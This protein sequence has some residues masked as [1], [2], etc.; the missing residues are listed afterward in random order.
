MWV[1]NV[2]A[3]LELGGDGIIASIDRWPPTTRSRLEPSTTATAASHGQLRGRR[4]AQV[5]HV[6]ERPRV[7]LLKPQAE[8]RRGAVLDVEGA[9]GEAITQLDRNARGD[10]GDAEVEPREHL[11]QPALGRLGHVQRQPPQLGQLVQAEHVIVMAVSE[12]HRLGDD[13]GPAQLRVGVGAGIDQHPAIDQDRRAQPRVAR[14]IRRALRA[15]A[16]QAG[17]RPR[18]S[19]TEKLHNHPGSVPVVPRR[20]LPRR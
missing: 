6:H 8:R 14:V 10:V 11:A 2:R 19:G 5:G 3:R 1:N 12:H 17:D 7:A 18:G 20:G 16:A 4:C 9:A 15:R 13:V